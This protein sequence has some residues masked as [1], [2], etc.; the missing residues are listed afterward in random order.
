MGL[1]QSSAAIVSAKSVSSEYLASVQL[2]SAFS[3]YAKFPRLTVF[4][5]HIQYLPLCGVLDYMA[6]F[7]SII[8]F[9][10]QRTIMRKRKD[11][12]GIRNSYMMIDMQEVAISL[13]TYY[14][15]IKE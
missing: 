6:L 14:S 3:S 9:Y 13:I 4:S 12:T 11:M 7:V 2:P 10:Y 15:T 1:H 5:L 8:L